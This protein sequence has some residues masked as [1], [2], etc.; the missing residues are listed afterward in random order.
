MMM[1]A[2]SSRNICVD[3][4]VHLNVFDKINFDCDKLKSKFRSFIFVLLK[5]QQTKTFNLCI[6]KKKALTT[7]TRILCISPLF[8][9]DLNLNGF[10]RKTKLNHKKFHFI[11]SY[12]NI[13]ENFKYVTLL[14]S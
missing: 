3:E 9:Y 4:K 1:N 14:D 6:C 8:C 13:I 10:E 12:F 7:L 5:E 11:F 2:T